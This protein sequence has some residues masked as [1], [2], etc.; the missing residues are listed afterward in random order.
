[1]ELSQLKFEA[2]G[3]SWTVDVHKQ[4]SESE[5]QELTTVI[6]ECVDRFDE[7]YS[8]FREESLVTS[9]SKKK[10]IHP[11][12]E[13]GMRMLQL[14]AKLYFISGGTFTPLVASLLSQA[15]YDASYSLAPQNIIKPKEWEKVLTLSDSEI[16]LSEPVLLDFGA[17]GKGELIDQIG[18]LLKQKGYSSYCI[19]GGGDI[20]Y[21]TQSSDVL[22][23]GLEHPNNL[24]QV[25]GVAEIK[26][27]S[28]C[29]SSGN[30]RKWGDFHHIINPHTLKPITSLLSTWVVAETA[31]LAD[32]L[33]TCLFF[34]P[35]GKLVEHFDFEYLVLFPDYTI[36][37]SNAFPAELY[38]N[39]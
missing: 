17:L 20:L 12:P 2:I 32:A 16:I 10:G 33:A 15:G 5:F 11:F 25:I 39:K 38:Y 8:R 6:R 9:L 35:P 34:V 26:N 14:Y 13:D 31:I 21:H 22:K 23:V 3:T 7:L 18:Y 1:M 19:D 30:R 4:L 28:I 36:N 37:K 29:A 24:Q 27:K